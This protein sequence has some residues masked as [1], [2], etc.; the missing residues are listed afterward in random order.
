MEILKHLNELMEWKSVS[1]DRECCKAALR[2]VLELAESFGLETK[3]GRYGDVGSVDLGAGPETVGVLVHVDVVAEGNPKLWDFEPY[4]L[5]E[6]DGILYGRGI[7]DD[8]GPVIASLY[9]LKKIKE[10][11]VPLKKRLRLIIGTSEEI[12]WTDMEHYIEEFELPDYGYS[13]DGNFP[14]YNQENGYMDVELRFDETLPEGIGGFTGGSAANSIP[15]YAAY[16]KEGATVAFTGKAAHSSSPEL[17]T[18]AINL[19]CEAVSR[20]YGL[21]FARVVQEYFPEG[22][23][24]SSFR[25]R[26]DDGSLSQKGDLTIVPTLLRQEGKSIF[27]NFN[28]RQS[29]GISCGSI[30]EGLKEKAEE[31]GYEV[32]VREGMEPIWVDENQPWIKRMQQV[33]ERYGM[34]PECLFAAGCSYA[35]SM[36]NFVVWG[37]VFPWDPDCAHMENE[38]QSLES[39]LR[40]LDMYTEYLTLEGQSEPIK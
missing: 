11:N 38:Q 9:A 32:I 10:A 30:V 18:N 3:V 4:R 37:P 29:C 15:S 39:F 2:Y 14:I 40:T 36:P 34:E 5:T 17:G 21:N 35:K 25:F 13:P 27:L 23:Y 24:E 22:N 31:C 26:K 19:L 1:E 6:K 8:K 20:E 7:V 16:E 33:T 28:V 12:Q